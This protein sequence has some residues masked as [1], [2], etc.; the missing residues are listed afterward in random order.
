MGDVADAI[1]FSQMIAICA[2][3]LVNCYDPSYASMDICDAAS[4]QSV[5][6][7]MSNS[8]NELKR[9]HQGLYLVMLLGLYS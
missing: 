3:Y 9:C 8:Y 7:S 4:V 1:Q 2:N 6:S 5:E